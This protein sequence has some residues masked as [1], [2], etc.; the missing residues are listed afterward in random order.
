MVWSKSMWKITWY[1]RS[2]IQKI[3][4]TETDESTVRTLSK[5]V[6]A[7]WESITLFEMAT[8]DSMSK[9]YVRRY[10][11]KSLEEELKYANKEN[12]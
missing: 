8:V 11:E 4:F 6:S 5:L 3:H 7:V 9:L 2:R 1:G 10:F 12:L